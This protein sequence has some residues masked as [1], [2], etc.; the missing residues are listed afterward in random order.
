MERTTAAFS[1]IKNKIQDEIDKSKESIKISVAWFTNKDLLGQL[2]IKVQNGCNVEII[3][4]D[5]LQNK[6]LSFKNF[7]ASG[8]KVLI[9]PTKSGKFLHDKFAIFDNKNLIA[10]SYNWTYTAENFNHEFVIQSDN[11]QLVKQF[12]FR[13]NNL[14]KIVINYDEQ[15]LSSYN[16]LTGTSKEEEFIQL[17]LELEAR[18]ID[19]VKEANVLGA[20]LKEASII[21]YIH[22]YGAIGGANRLI[23]LGTDRMQSGL[24][25]LWEIKRLDLSFESIIQQDKFKIL[26]D[27]DILEKAQKRLNE[28]DK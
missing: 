11:E 17:E 12:N 9:M 14:K 28:L 21:P 16:E 7:I 22:Q 1:G 8:G 15:V 3:I 27:K 13:F 25:K 20:K 4:S 2:E 23:K 18:F 26:F 24:I 5:D 10:G 6:R 19:S